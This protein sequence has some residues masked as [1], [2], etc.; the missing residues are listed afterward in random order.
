MLVLIIATEGSNSKG[1]H[2][3]KPMTEKREERFVDK[4]KELEQ[5]CGSL[6]AANW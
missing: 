6:V 4:E 1:L 2:V 5:I 3:K